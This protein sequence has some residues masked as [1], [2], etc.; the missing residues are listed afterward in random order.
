MWMSTLCDRADSEFWRV[1]VGV[2]TVGCVST[3]GTLFLR[4]RKLRTPR[5]KVRFPKIARVST[6][7]KL[8]I[9]FGRSEFLS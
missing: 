4:F 6:S 7:L 2:S 3:F 1:S 9:M 5:L 8:S